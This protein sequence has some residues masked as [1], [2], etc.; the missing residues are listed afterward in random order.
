MNIQ[1]NW[2]IFKIRED[3]VKLSEAL[4]EILEAD[5]SYLIERNKVTQQLLIWIKV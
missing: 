3:D 5:S 1:K 2:L 4:K